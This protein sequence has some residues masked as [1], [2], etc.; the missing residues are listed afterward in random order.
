MPAAI[1]RLISKLTAQG[2]ELIAPYRKNRVRWATQD[3]RSLERCQ[4]YPIVP[5]SHPG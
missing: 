4:Q 1:I 5:I 2:I 3:G